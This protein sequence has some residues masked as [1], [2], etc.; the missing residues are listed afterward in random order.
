MD[1]WRVVGL[2]NRP[3]HGVMAWLKTRE[4]CTDFV[5]V[6]RR[7]GFHGKEIIC[8]A[9]R[10]RFNR[11]PTTVFRKSNAFGDLVAVWHVWPLV[12]RYSNDRR[13]GKTMAFA[14]HVDGGGHTNPYAW[15]TISDH[16]CVYASAQMVFKSLSTSGG[17]KEGEQGNMINPPL[18]LCVCIGYNVLLGLMTFYFFLTTLTLDNF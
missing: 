15:Y 8:T 17:S 13:C 7:I 18:E 14:G 3:R 9:G 10:L 16:T 11:T 4:V 1:Y 12:K 5:R 2:Y 6:C